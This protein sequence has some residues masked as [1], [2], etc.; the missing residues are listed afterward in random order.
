MLC[1]NNCTN[2]FLEHVQNVH[3]LKNLCDYI[4]GDMLTQLEKYPHTLTY[5]S[6]YFLRVKNYLKILHTVYVL[7]Q[8]VFNLVKSALVTKK[9]HIA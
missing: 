6:I 9:G 7:N 5:F 1:W 2:I 3:S 8:M 4:V